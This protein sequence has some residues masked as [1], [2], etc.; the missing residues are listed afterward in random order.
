MDQNV[1][2]STIDGIPAFWAPGPGPFRA[3]LM[4]RSGVADE[5][6][7]TR[8][9]T[10]LVEHLA[11]FASMS[12][13]DDANGFVD[14][15]RTV[16]YA[17]GDRDEVL[18]WLPRCSAA[19]TNLPLE[20]L[21]TERRILR[22]EAGSQGG[23]ILAR[24]LDLHL[25]AVSY[26]LS[27]YRELGLR[28]LGEEQV[29]AWARAR[30]NRGNAVLWMSGEPP[31]SLSLDLPDGERNPPA[32]VDLL[33]AAQKGR[34]F[35]AGGSG[36]L[37]IGGIAPR[38]TPLN[39]AMAIAYERLYQQLRV[40]LGL[41]YQPW[42]NYERLGPAHAHVMLGAECPDERAA[43]VAEE[44]W[45]IVEDIA[46]H[47]VTAEEL[48]DH[49]RRFKRNLEDPD[50]IYGEL[51][52][53]ASQE[54][55]GAPP[56]DRARVAEEIEAIVPGEPIAEVAEAFEHAMAAIPEAVTF[57]GFEAYEAVRPSPVRPSEIL[58]YDEKMAGPGVEVHLAGEGITLI[59]PSEDPL[60]LH[61]D[62]IVLVE[63]APPDTLTLTARDGSWLELPFASLDRD[64][65][66]VLSR[67][68]PELVIPS[69]NIE[70]AE[71]LGALVEDLPAEVQI[72]SEL[73]ALTRELG[74]DEL[75]EAVMPYRHG[76]KRGMLALTNERLFRWYRGAEQ[77]DGEAIPRAA[78]RRAEV[79]KRLLRAPV[80]VVEHE[81][82]LEVAVDDPEAA[83]ELA[84]R[85][86]A[87]PDG[88]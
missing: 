19:L 54:L 44:V 73:A 34:R 12:R 83:E 32:P 31:D 29:A 3:A 56:V 76:D 79:R 27:Q 87:P 58:A 77:S 4:F 71:A 38:S 17:A 60:T 15:E 13:S 25:G 86:A 55:L 84:A 42:V 46:E 88:A 28:W 5:T 67:V 50:A 59:T 43:R 9:I 78:I 16:L 61:W 8:G 10:H 30:F 26:G 35:V 68:A 47:G 72:D 70:A 7:P 52:D 39:A 81:K 33:E 49:T 82:A 80:L 85:L 2:R 64:A 69:G 21:A 57:A 37:A 66:V 65:E 22:T 53:A 18:E 6:L 1:E 36:G 75:P 20:R 24:L 74:E 48:A 51:D 63:T 23:S 45:K 11:L 40:N 14:L 41:V 62:E